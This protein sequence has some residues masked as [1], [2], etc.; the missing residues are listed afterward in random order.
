MTR[1]I[2]F[3]VLLLLIFAASLCF[4][5]W[6]TAG[7][8]VTDP[9]ESNYALTAKEMV[10]SGDWISPQIYGKYWYDKP[11]LVYWLLSV[12]YTLFGFTD[13][14]SRL[15][16]ALCGALSV[17][18]MVYYMKRVTG[19]QDTALWAGAFLSTSLE[20][21]I[22]SHAIITDSMLFLFTV[23]TL[24]SAYIGITEKRPVHMA[25]AYASA[26]IACLAK[27]PVGLVLPGIILFFWCCSLRSRQ[28]FFYLFHPLGILAFAVAALPW[29]VTMYA[30][31]GMDFVNGFLGLHNVTRA[32]ASEHPRD[33]H[34]YYYLLVTPLSLLPWTGLAFYGMIRQWSERTSLYK[35]LFSWFWVTL[36][37][38]TLVATKYITYTY[39]AAAPAIAFAAMALPEFKAG[40]RQT[41]FV[42]LLPF[43]LTMT[44]LTAGS[45]FIAGHFLVFYLIAGI[46]MALLLIL[47]KKRNQ[48]KILLFST[49]AM[50]AALSCLVVSGLSGYIA[51]RSSIEMAEYFHSLPG[52]HYFYSSYAASF[53]YYT[54]ETATRLHSYG[55]TEK[56]D[57][58]WDEKYTMPSITPE[59]LTASI[60]KDQQI[61]LFVQKNALDDFAANPIHKQFK[62]N[63]V[64]STGTIYEAV[65]P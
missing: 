5:L 24:F 22:I 40:R 25:V 56:R 59:A 50:A 36:L 19:R 55:G 57:T 38:Y 8:P 12:S 65:K 49:C 7:M 14:A 61:Y 30:I 11:A 17:T 9:V 63:K 44:A 37:F 47:W 27:G 51:S 31:H 58:R 26:G 6:G 60:G 13:F 1:S 43:F 34:F 39:I 16:S 42:V 45:F 54:G 41:A 10:L 52:K 33:N 4:F 62:E 48:G 2:R 35:L 53:T 3:P 20:F 18:L 29:Y 32:L 64:F 23:P 15:P 28:A 46:S 21:W